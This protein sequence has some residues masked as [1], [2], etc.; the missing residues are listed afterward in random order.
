MN[1]SGTSQRLPERVSGAG[2]DTSF[3][4]TEASVWLGV[5]R[6]FRPR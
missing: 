3:L 4:S 5:N 1:S 2:S 6:M